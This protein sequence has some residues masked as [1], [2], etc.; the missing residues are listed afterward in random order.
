[1]QNKPTL[2]G[3][4]CL[5]TCT[6]VLG[7][8]QAGPTQI[9]IDTTLHPALSGA[10]SPT[11]TTYLITPSYGVTSGTNEFFSFQT[12]NLTLSDTAQFQ[13]ASSITNIVSRVT[14]GVGT[15]IDGTVATRITGTSTPSSANFWFVNPAGVVITSNARFD[16]AGSIS[17]GAADSIKFSS[18]EQFFADPAQTLTLSVAS[19][20]SFGFL[21]TSTAGTLQASNWDYLFNGTLN[22]AGGSGVT[23][24]QIVL[25]A[26][27]DTTS[28]I[29]ITSNTGPVK[30]LSSGL[31]TLRTD[32]GLSSGDIT[33]TGAS[34]LADNSRISANSVFGASGNV[35][36]TATGADPVG[37]AALQVQNGALLQSNNNA[38]GVS[39]SVTLTANNGT[40]YVT[41]ATTGL[42][43]IGTGTTLLQGANITVDGA[44]LQA[45]GGAAR[46]PSTAAITLNATGAVRITNGLITAYGA[47]AD[48]GDIAITGG[49]I[50]VAGSLDATTFLTGNAGNITLTATGADPQGGKALQVVTGGTLSSDAREAG[51]GPV[52]PLGNAGNITLNAP[53]GTVQLAGGSLSTSAAAQGGAA[54]TISIQGSAIAFNG[55]TVS[56]TAAGTNAAASPGHIVLNGTGAVTLNGTT[57]SSTTSGANTA[58]DI[59]ISGSSVDVTGSQVTAAT[60]GTGNAGKIVVTATGT[61]AAAGAS[62]LLISGGSA[63][64][65][66]ASQGLSGANAGSVTL[67]A[68]NGTAQ[69]GLLT[70]T[71]PVF[72]ET[73]TGAS[74]GAVGP[75][76]VGGSGVIINGARLVA[77]ADSNVD[78]QTTDPAISVTSTVAPVLITGNS[79]LGAFTQAGARGGDIVVTGPAVVVNGGSTISASTLGSGNAGSISIAATGADTSTAPAL[80]VS[81]GA[82]VL[83]QAAA[84]ASANAGSVSLSAPNGTVQVGLATDATPAHVSTSAAA[85]AGRVGD[86]SLAGLNVAVDQSDVDATSASSVSAATNQPAILINATGGTASIVDHGRVESQTTA[87]GNAAD[88]AINGTAIVVNGG[89]V[90]ADT[91]GSGNAGTV[92]L[93][94]SGADPSG[95][96][97][98][99]ITGQSQVT[100]DA[101][102][103]Q[104][105]A[106][107]AGITMTASRGTVQIG[108]A[109][110]TPGAG[111][112]V[113][114]S[115]GAQAGE[116]GSID[117]TGSQ[118]ALSN[119]QILTTV[120]TQTAVAGQSSASVELAATGAVSLANSLIDL[121]TSGVIDAGSVTMAATGELTIANSTL[122]SESVGSTGY[123]GGISLSGLGVLVSQQSL[124][125]GDYRNPGGHGGGPG[126]ISIFA[127]GS[128]NAGDPLQNN[129]TAATPGV[130]RIVDSGVTASNDGGLGT[131]GNIGQNGR[132]SVGADL[133]GNGSLSTYDTVISGSVISTDVLDNG[134]GNNLFVGGSH[135]VYVG[136]SATGGFADPI[137]RP[138]FPDP[139]SS[140]SSSLISAQTDAT[141]D[142]GGQISLSGGAG[143]VTVVSSNID[144][145]TTR[146]ASG[147]A[148]QTNGGGVVALLAAVLQTNTLNSNRSG[149]IAIEGST[150]SV[151]GGTS[152]TAKTSGAGNAG[153]ISIAA[154]AADPQGGAA[155]RISGGSLVTSDALQGLAGANAGHV[156]LTADAGTVQV[157]VPADLGS[158][159]PTMLST[160]VG[161]TGGQVG[162]V[163]IHGVNVDMNNAQV[164]ATTAS[165]VQP[166]A[167]QAAIDIEATTGGVTLQSSDLSSAT[168]SAA[169]AADI[170][171]SGPYVSITGG[172]VTAKTTG[173]GSAGNIVLTATGTAGASGHAALQVAGGAQISSDASAGQSQQTNAG[174]INL[175]ADQGSVQVG[176]TA[177]SS[178]TP[179]LLST[180]AGAAAGQVGYISI[181]G[182]SVAITNAQLAAKT[183]SQINP[184]AGKAAISVQSSGATTLSG[185][186]LSA[187]TSSGAI[188]SDIQ[189][190]GSSVS[191]Q[192][193]NITASTTGTGNAGSISIV[194]SGASGANG[195]SALLVSGGANIA[196]DASQGQSPQTNAGYVKL[197]ASAGT[198]QVGASGDSTS[199]VISNSVGANAGAPG[200]VTIAGAGVDLE[201]AQ[202]KTTTASTASSAT[203]GSIVLNAGDGTGLLKVSNS[204]LDAATSG[205]Q[206]AGEIDLVGSPIQINNSTVSSATTG[207]G[208]AGAICVSSSCAGVSSAAGLVGATAGASAGGVAPL[209]TAGGSGGISI[210]GS[211]LST[212]TSSTGTGGDI[213]VSTPGALVLTASQIESQSTAV[214]P[215]AGAVG[216]I[217]L[218]GGS[219]NL[220][221]SI[222]SAISNGGTA[223]ASTTDVPG[224]AITIN[225]TG[226]Q[227]LLSIIGSQ[228]TTQA[229]VTNGSNIVVNAG[230]SQVKLSNSVITASATAGNGGN[231]TVNNAGDTALERSAIVAQAGPGNGGAINIGLK[232]G[233]VFVQDSESLV[234]ATSKSGN[235]G[236]V[237]INSPQTDLNSALRVPEVSA[238][239]APELTANVCRHEGSHSTFVKEGRGGVVADPEG[240]L[241]GSEGPNVTGPPI[242]V[243]AQTAP[244]SLLVSAIATSECP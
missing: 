31:N 144:A 243:E 120:S 233:A 180:S 9:V 129:L 232:Q 158:A 171:V 32:S 199:S 59:T 18:G 72:I 168:S 238:A 185:G 155:L 40:V 25:Q 164:S 211:K 7:Q 16:T 207:A 126:S 128:E 142:S 193:G 234:S 228:I 116:A 3:T 187:A 39:G 200:T 237:T 108:A 67:R 15:T 195:A 70:D 97:A 5:V 139:R 189:I 57:L 36:L 141:A 138:T 17:L 30:V 222:I 95:S 111:T 151:D 201:D 47:S 90:T 145:G 103:G 147:I 73:N 175:S 179:T 174:T 121:R 221:G 65:S 123:G 137:A 14:G 82:S 186:D 48:A 181:S 110:D 192:G 159:T 56:T 225:S 68:P 203:R 52:Q 42:S 239:R 33:I 157:G 78:P 135:G 206:Q 104:N 197:T 8:A 202:I 140:I 204:S 96:A 101:S 240:Y 119:A 205:V 213:T 20:V 134:I 161:A 88:I 19:P 183:A 74:A 166:V 77:T 127:T 91:T 107:A 64:S 26:Q 210:T 154:T 216:V 35:T 125:S 136:A 6:C 220:L 124:I 2:V 231:I 34:V 163:N 4:V 105:G 71:T 242:A 85:G 46:P 194:A 102:A 1:M 29:V 131:A 162:F 81:G 198:V 184:P 99:K 86:I 98:L 60:T 172:S 23:L 165:A 66:D 149:D 148:I 191:I 218:S 223:V 44:T 196:S 244:T 62:A 24:N 38:G 190:G 79:Q 143:G 226:G 241:R 152:I 50:V 112:V 83:S 21:P 177:D 117:I 89:V 22:L 215:T 51:G 150:V 69:F 160:A 212:S 84:G 63:I 209:A 146:T 230:G 113:S 100:T 153:N 156:S 208:S 115:A 93:V 114:T 53:Q 214:G 235:N 10:I 13:A 229:Q 236:T 227:D 167:G 87:S 12:F 109:T 11:G 54:G 122:S 76:V 41:G 106:N 55:G 92:S 45:A 182:A 176:L 49:S 27:D 118:I 80:E 217:N 219:V 133:Q 173:V 94:A 58:G 61:D 43:T 224:A 170:M 37:G 130:V 188:A 132:I 169:R 178:V 75:I 28:N